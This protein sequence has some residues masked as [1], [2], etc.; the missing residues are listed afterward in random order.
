MQDF[1]ANRDFFSKFW[2][3]VTFAHNHIQCL[4]TTQDFK[5]LKGK[6]VQEHK[7]Q[8]IFGILRQILSPMNKN[9]GI[10]WKII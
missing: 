7:I 4:M 3:F 1:G 6:G 5:I 9:I 2:T 8:G 10:N